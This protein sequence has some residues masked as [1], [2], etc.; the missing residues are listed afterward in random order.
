MK[1][2]AEEGGGPAGVV[3]GWEAKLFAR[4]RLVPGVEGG[5]ED[6]GTV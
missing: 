3:D 1:D 4:R 6:R 5:L 2:R